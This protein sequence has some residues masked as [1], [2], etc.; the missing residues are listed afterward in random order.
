MAGFLNKVTLI[1]N[2]GRD[3]EVRNTQSGD[4]VVSF[5]LATTES[6]KDRQSGERRERT[7]W[8]RVVIFGNGLAGIAEQYLRQGSKVYVEG[9]LQTRKWQDQSGADRYA[10]EIALKPY[11]GNLILLDGNRSGGS[12]SG[13]HGD[14]GP[15]DQDEFERPSGADLDDE[16]PF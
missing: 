8:H 15:R 5:S 10:T 13:G 2:I 12:R 1:G 3:P 16:V 6:W 9:S 7:E 4:K 14:A 11:N